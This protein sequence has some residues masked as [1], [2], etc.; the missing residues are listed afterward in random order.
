MH[1]AWVR[2]NVEEISLVKEKEE[3]M[4]QEISLMKENIEKIQAKLST[5]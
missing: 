4:L 3:K 1:F 5:L 2:K